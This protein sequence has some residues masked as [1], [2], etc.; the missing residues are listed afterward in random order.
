MAG[1][2]PRGRAHQYTI[3]EIR[4]WMELFY[5]RFFANQFKRS[6]L[7]NGPKALAAGRSRRAE[8]GG[9]PPTS[10][11]RRGSTKCLGFL[12]NRVYSQMRRGSI[13]ELI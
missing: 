13:P 2:F 10:L 8:T 1:G 6:T 9:C 5:K 11:L 3:G 7:P 12:A 4:S